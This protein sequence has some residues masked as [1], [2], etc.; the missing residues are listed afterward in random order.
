M[1][2]S[3]RICLPFVTLAVA[4]C[5]SGGGG[6]GYTP[7]SNLV[8]NTYSQVLDQAQKS[9]G[10]LGELE[11]ASIRNTF[12]PRAGSF[13]ATWSSSAVISNP[14]NHSQNITAQQYMLVQLNPNAV[15]ADNGSSVNMFGRLKQTLGVFCAIGVAAGMS[16]VAVDASGYPENGTHAVTLTAAILSQLSTQCN[17]DVQGVSPGEQL[18]LVVASASGLYDKSLGLDG[19]QQ[20]VLVKSDANVIN[21]AS[22]EVHDDGHSVSR[23]VV[24]WNKVS[25]VLLAQYNSDPGTGHS[26]SGGLYAYR[27]YYDEAGDVSQ[28]LTYEGPAN[29]LA[30]ATRYSM[31]GKPDVG[32]AVSLSFQHPGINS[33]TSVDACVNASTGDLVPDGSRC[34]ATSTTL[35]GH[36]IS[37]GATASMFSSF[38][39]ANGNSSWATVTNSTT[40]S[41]NSTS[42]WT[43]TIAP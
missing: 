41:W 18:A 29:S 11:S 37:T 28:L 31:V 6:G 42:M 5:S 16:G 24:Q 17:M 30:N 23:A 3:L 7:V 38:Q 35:V 39:A 36:D 22:G 40:I 27:L 12:S 8:T 13:G 26:G 15:Q 21:I 43:A 4:A 14:I 33:G 20:T 10:G 34:S 25:K 9:T 1:R 32:T 2:V 19:M